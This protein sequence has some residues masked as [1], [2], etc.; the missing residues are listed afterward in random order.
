MR[1]RAV[2]TLRLSGVAAQRSLASVLAPDNEGLPRG[3]SLSMAGRGATMK[4]AVDAG[5]PSASVSTVLALLRDISLFQEVW[6]L[7]HGSEPMSGPNLE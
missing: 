2:L 5:S 3:L 4:C 6:L 1:S 7:S